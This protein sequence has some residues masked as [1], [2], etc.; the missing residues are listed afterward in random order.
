[1]LSITPDQMCAA[2]GY[3]AD[4]WGD[5]GYRI[6]QVE[7]ATPR[8][9]LFHVCASDGSRFI[10][11][12]DRYGNC[13]YTGLHGYDTPEHTAALVAALV[14]EMEAHIAACLPGR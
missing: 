3:I 10:V 1:M 12:G 5:Y 4:N 2:G 11:A 8:V 6:E 13:R 14:T 9:A 7:S